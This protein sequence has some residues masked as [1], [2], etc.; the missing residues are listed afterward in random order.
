MFLQNIDLHRDAL[1][2]HASK[3]TDD[4]FRIAHRFGHV[5]RKKSEIAVD[6]CYTE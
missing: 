3:R 4:H 5:N 2:K 1:Q 6:F